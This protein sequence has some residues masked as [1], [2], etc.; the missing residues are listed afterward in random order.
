MGLGSYS[1]HDMD[2][3]YRN[4]EEKA[5]AGMLTHEGSWDDFY[6]YAADSKETFLIK[7][8]LMPVD[9]FPVVYVVRDGRLSIES[10]LRQYQTRLEKH[11]GLDKS[12]PSYIDLVIGHDYYSDWSTHYNSWQR[13]GL[14]PLFQLKYEEIELMSD[15]RMQ[16]L[17]DFVNYT[18]EIKH[19]VN[20]LLEQKKT[21]P[22]IKDRGQCSW[23]RPAHRTEQEEAFFIALHSNLMLKLGYV[24]ELEVKN[25]LL[26]FDEMALQLAKSAMLIAKERYDLQRVA[27]EKETV[28]QHFLMQ[29]GQPTSGFMSKFKSWIK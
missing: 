28:I 19:F 7:T 27:M 26:M 22:K 16:E 3:Y 4:E 1:A 9:D 12:T 2:G 21:D 25:S 5:E 18:G 23:I 20:P 24:T 8:H 15:I 11:P 6:Q 13:G 14:A 29:Q 10:Y 17:A